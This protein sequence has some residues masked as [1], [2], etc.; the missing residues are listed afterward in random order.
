MVVGRAGFVIPE[1]MQCPTAVLD[2]LLGH[3]RIVAGTCDN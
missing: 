1:F 2:G 3:Q